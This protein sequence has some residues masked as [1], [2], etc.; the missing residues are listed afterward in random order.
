MTEK[1][2]HPATFSAAVLDVMD[3]WIPKG[4][5]DEPVR[6]LDPLAGIGKGPER[7]NRPQDYQLA[8]GIEL[9]QEWASQSPLVACGDGIDYMKTHPLTFDVVATS[10]PFHNRASDSHNQSP[11]DTSSRNTYKHKLGRDLTTGSGAGLQWTNPDTPAWVNRLTNG[12]WRTI[13]HGGLF[14]FEMKDHVRNGKR[15]YVTD[16]YVQDAMEVG[17]TL[18]TAETVFSRGLPGANSALKVPY[19]TVVVMQKV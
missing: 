16:W 9:E 13:R 11:N 4:T 17:F 19:S 18:L 10:P 2:K 14:I 1:V 15:Q 6:I 3:H 12:C 5:K 8:C 7:F